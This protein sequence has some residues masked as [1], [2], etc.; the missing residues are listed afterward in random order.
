MRCFLIVIRWAPIPI[1]YLTDNM[2][3]QIGYNKLT[4]GKHPKSVWQEHNDLWKRV[5]I[6]MDAKGDDFV[7]VSHVKEHANETHIALG[8]AT[9]RE[10]EANNQADIRAVKG[11][12]EDE[13][14]HENYNPWA[15]DEERFLKA[16]N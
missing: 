11:V 12:K 3:V 16:K 6:A 14:F 10:A 15:Q 5:K 8:Q 4:S 13:E 7:I 2:A 9:W 1:E